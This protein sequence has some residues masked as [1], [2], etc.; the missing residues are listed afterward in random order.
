MMG[1]RRARLAPVLVLVALAAMAAI[2]MAA[3]IIRSGDDDPGA[4]TAARAQPTVPPARAPR[5]PQSAPTAGRSAAEAAALTAA[6]RFLKGYLPYSYG[7]GR[8]SRI[9]AAASPLAATL[10]RSPPRVP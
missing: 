2:A 1:G 6:R 3:V 8:A 7:R 4:R 10:Q 9:E 5:E